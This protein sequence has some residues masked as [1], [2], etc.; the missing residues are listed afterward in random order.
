MTTRVQ[1]VL[2]L[3]AAGE[4]VYDQTILLSGWVYAAGRDPATC[5]VRAFLEEDCLA[6]TTHLFQRR[7]VCQHLGLA[8]SVPTGFRMLGRTSTGLT[9]ARD[10]TLRLVA[11]Y[12]DDLEHRFAEQRVR[13]IP[14]RL[15]DRPH[16]EVVRP[17]NAA[18]LHREN[19]Y[20]SGP[21]AELPSDEAMILVENYLPEG[22]SIVDV[23]CG[24]GAY[25]DRLTRAGH[26]WVGLEA[27]P[28]CCAIL[29]RRR[30]PFRKV[31]L[32]SGRLPGADQEWDCAICIEVL[33]HIAEPETFLREI[34]R[35]TRQRALFSVPNIEV[36]PYLHDWGVVPWHMLEADHKNFFT[37]ASLR[38]LLRK[39]F[40][41]AEVF[42]YGQHS[43]RTRDGIAVFSHLFAITEV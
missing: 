33:E 5:R 43:L 13:L 11:S 21:P 10:A 20:G 36:L 29:E 38:A 15:R 14:A 16:G 25:A 31:D 24:A 37:R 35:I 19:I 39:A 42:P 22:A 2:D 6:E 26:D 28:D 40:R 7:D 9:E 17:D 23:G 27:N 18:L 12:H 32:P 1:G 8:D 30:L 41:T 3:P 4:T 34:R